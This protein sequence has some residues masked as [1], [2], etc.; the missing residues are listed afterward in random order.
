MNGVALIKF[1]TSLLV[2]FRLWRENL[3]YLKILVGE[4]SHLWPVSC[5][6]TVARI[7]A[8]PRPTGSTP[9][10]F[11]QLQLKSPSGRGWWWLLLHHACIFQHVGPFSASAR[12]A[13]LEVL[14]EMISPVELLG[15]IAFPE[16]VVVLQMANTLIPILFCDVS[17]VS[18]MGET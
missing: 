9:L 18:R 3:L 11:P 6:P 12:V 13:V 16:L 14:A 17:Q 4:S 2:A 7:T 5:C 10:A 8:V 1:V 15:A